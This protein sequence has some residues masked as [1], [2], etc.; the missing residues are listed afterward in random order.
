MKKYIDR[1]LLLDDVNHTLF[2]DNRDRSTVKNLVLSIPTADVVEVVRCGECKHRYTPAR[3][4]LW[5]ATENDNAVFK[6]HG[7]DFF[8]AFGERKEG[9]GK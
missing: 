1:D 6:E 2:Y 7:E 3:C 4:S 8:C 9:E 5:V